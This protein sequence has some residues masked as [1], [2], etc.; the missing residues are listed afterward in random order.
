MALVSIHRLEGDVAAVLGDLTGNLFRK[1]LKAL[2]ALF[3]VILG[4]DLHAHAVF[5]APRLML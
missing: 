5:L 1:A 2:L 4:I 3:A